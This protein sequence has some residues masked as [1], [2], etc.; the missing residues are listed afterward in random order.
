MYHAKLDVDP[1]P[2]THTCVATREGDWIVHRCPICDYELWDNW[3]TGDLQIF[4]SKINIQHS[5]SYVDPMIEESAEQL[6]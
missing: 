2:D 1:V 5:G 6:N 3:K 4:N